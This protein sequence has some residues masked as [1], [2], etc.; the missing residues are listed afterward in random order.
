MSRKAQ[1]YVLDEPI[2]GV[3]PAARDYIL[4]TILSNYSEEASVLLSTHLIADVENVLDDVIFIN[5]G[6]ILLQQS[7]DQIRQEKGCSVDELFRE[8]FRY[9]E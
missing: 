2:A 1:L 5:K 7:V 3:D 6:R 9:A 4:G 8:V